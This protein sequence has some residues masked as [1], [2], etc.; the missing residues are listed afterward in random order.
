MKNIRLS[1]ADLLGDR[2]CRVLAQCQ[3]LLTGRPVAELVKLAEE[4]VDFY[5]A[6]FAAR[7][8]ALALRTGEQLLEGVGRT[9]EGAPTAAFAKSQHNDSA[10]LAAMGCSRVGE[11]GKIR[12]IAKSEHYHASLGHQFPGYRLLDIAR[13]LGIPNATHNNTRGILTRLLERELVRLANDLPAG[14]EAALERALKT[15]SPRVLNRVINLETGSLAVEA[16]LKMMLARFYR[17]DLTFPEPRYADRRPVFLTLGDPEHNCAA[18]YHGTTVLTQVLRGMWP[19]FGARLAACGAYRVEYVRYNDRAAFDAMIERFDQG[20]YKIAGFLHELV[21][22]NYGAIRLDNDFV[23]HIYRVC[24]ERDIPTLVDEIQSCMW[25]PRLFLFH[26]YG[27]VP[28][29]VSVGK[30][31]PGGQ[32]P[33]SRL[34]TNARMD[35]LNQ[36]G[37]LV[38]NGQEE[39]AALAYLA[40]I[41]FAEA[42]RAETVTTGLHY[43]EKARELAA[44]FPQYLQKIEGD[45]LLLSFF[46]REEKAT[47]DFVARMVK[48]GFDVSAQ[49]YKAHCPPAVL[50]KP[51][52]T[53]T[54]KMIDFMLEKMRRELAAMAQGVTK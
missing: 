20:D 4:K 50:T 15:T 18:N 6:D 46:F 9:V 2:H 24:E 45:G 54:P 30:G 51:P 34:I 19:E 10:P 5:P 25:A 37:A 14:D 36:F 23:R 13:E 38:T 52:L 28:D 48:A 40:T 42:N 16:G 31:F 26:E 17:L 21:L 41:R 47:R 22:M 7:V 27:I 8:E 35:S 49:T 1:L 3:S 11:D 29:F 39:L 12:F 33:A 32:Y 53:A 44:E 43:Q